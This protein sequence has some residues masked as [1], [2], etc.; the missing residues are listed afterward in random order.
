MNDEL[1]VR[2]AWNTPPKIRKLLER[3]EINRHGGWVWITTDGPVSPEHARYRID[4]GRERRELPLLEAD[5]EQWDGYSFDLIGLRVDWP[6]IKAH[7][8]DG[9]WGDGP[10]MNWGEGFDVVVR[11]MR[12]QWHRKVEIP[13]TDTYRHRPSVLFAEYVVSNRGG[14]RLDRDAVIR[15]CHR[16]HLAEDRDR[17][18]DA[19]NMILEGPRR[20]APKGKRGPRDPE[21]RT[22]WLR[23]EQN[24]WEPTR[25]EHKAAGGTYAEW[26]QIARHK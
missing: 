4:D 14:G 7:I 21:R 3:L 26:K 2:R 10:V 18:W 5:V 17:A 9:S 22:W 15:G 23:A 16:W 6:S 12:A 19:M 1:A 8:G 25:A 20:G 13:N 11:Y 24:G